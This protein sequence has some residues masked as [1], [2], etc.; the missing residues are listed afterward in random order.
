MISM[1]LAQH[2]RHFAA[3]KHSC[4]N[5]LAFEIGLDDKRRTI[6]TGLL[7][8]CTE[9]SGTPMLFEPTIGLGNKLPICKALP[10]VMLSPRA[11]RIVN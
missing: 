1:I 2:V 8:L 3:R 11:V 9:F 10:S 7:I 6:V 5:C 4:L